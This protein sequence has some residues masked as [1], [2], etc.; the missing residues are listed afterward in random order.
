MVTKEVAEPVGGL[1]DLVPTSTCVLVEGVLSETPEGTKQKV[2][3]AL[4]WLGGPATLCWA[5]R[6]LPGRATLCL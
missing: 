5:G 6:A 3:V 2:G 4:S 1:K